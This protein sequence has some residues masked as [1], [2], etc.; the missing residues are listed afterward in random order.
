MPES[1]VYIIFF[2]FMIQPLLNSTYFPDDDIATLFNYAK[3]IQHIPHY[4]VNDQ[5]T[6]LSP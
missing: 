2:L 3:S 1:S 4:L 5:Q 6:P